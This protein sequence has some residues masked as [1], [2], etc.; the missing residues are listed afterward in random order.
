MRDQVRLTD[1]QRFQWLR[2]W[3]SEQVGPAS[4]R[5]LI[6]RFGSA[7]LALEALPRLSAEGGTRS[8][9]AASVD[10]IEIELDR[11][12]SCG[13]R[14]VAFGEPEYPTALFHL[15]NAPPLLAVRGNVEHLTKPALAIVG[16]RNASINGMRMAA[17]LAHDLGQL[18]ICIV[19]GMA[20]GIDRAAHEGSMKTGTI[21]VLAG[22]LDA[23]YPPQNNDIFEHIISGNGSAVSTMP[24][25][26]RA[27]ARDFPRRNAIIAGAALGVIVV[28]AAEKSGSLITARLANEAGRFV[29]AVPGFP[30]DPRSNGCNGLIREGAVL[31]RSAEDVM[32]LMGPL[33]GSGSQIQTKVV[34]DERSHNAA[35]HNIIQS[36]PIV[37][38]AA[39]ETEP[40]LK[41][42][43][44]K[45]PE[46]PADPTAQ[47]LSL[48]GSGPSD[49]DE[50][51][52][53]SGLPTAQVLA[54]VTELEIMGQ[55]ERHSGGT[56]SLL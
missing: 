39:Q 38:V 29:L 31:I 18:G 6:N 32:E 42:A 4:F 3:R 50:V 10:D 27:T 12:A 22:G 43:E 41:R 13:A 19:S 26:H 40:R 1:R 46:K 5:Q 51:I 49:I 28:E 36:K 52:R 54:A 56:I 25:G 44:Q 17:Q 7:E 20:R 55:I 35:S 21:A 24:F 53:Q 2:L 33:I 48:L 23:P 47:I 37:T 11:A 9:K 15:E 14:F 8:Y 45:Q 30:L 16:S 34:A